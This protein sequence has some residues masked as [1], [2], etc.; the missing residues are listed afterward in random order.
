MFYA[1]EKA[2]DVNEIDRLRTLSEQP[3]VHSYPF[4]EIPLNTHLFHVD[5]AP[6]CDESRWQRFVFD[7]VEN[8][9]A[10]AADEKL[11]EFRIHVQTRRVH[12]RDYQLKRVVEIACGVA[13]SGEVAY[14]FSCADGSTEIGSLNEISQGDLVRMST[15]WVEPN[16]SV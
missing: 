5:V 3:G 2:E 1:Y 6:A 14:V 10:F 9:F 13:S 4:V 7:R 16:I 12:E 8:I 11:Q 15:L